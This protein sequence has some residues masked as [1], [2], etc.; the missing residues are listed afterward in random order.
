M[1]LDIEKIIFLFMV[2]TLANECFHALLTPEIT[3][4]TLNL[5]CYGSTLSVS[6]LMRAFLITVS[7]KL[8]SRFLSLSNPSN[9]SFKYANLF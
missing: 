4:Y 9:Q 7:C 6:I 8:V 1:L 2:L 3:I 5:Y